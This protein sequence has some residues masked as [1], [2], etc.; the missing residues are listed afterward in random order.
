MSRGSAL[1][2][3]FLIVLFRICVQI[4]SIRDAGLTNTMVGSLD[5]AALYPSL[6]HKGSAEAA[7]IFVLE[8]AIDSRCIDWQAAQVF[9]SSNLSES[10]VKEE[11]LEGLVPRRL[12]R[13]GKKP[14]SSQ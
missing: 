3:V 10:Q 8:S 11:S 14:S 9:L 12:K 5:V 6:D 1:A 13:R 7:E 4:V 2:I